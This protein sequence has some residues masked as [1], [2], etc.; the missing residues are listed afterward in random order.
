MSIVTGTSKGG[1]VS[2]SLGSTGGGVVCG[3]G[4]PPITGG[5]TFFRHEL[6]VPATIKTAIKYSNSLRIELVVNITR[7]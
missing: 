1:C 4:G 5:K 7:S 2:S 6:T 3:G